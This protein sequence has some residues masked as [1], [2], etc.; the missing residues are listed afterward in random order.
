MRFKRPTIVILIFII[1]LFSSCNTKDVTE[2][3]IV[4][5]TVCKITG[6]SQIP[7]NQVW[8]TLRNLESK[9]NMNTA[10]SEIDQVNAKA[11]LEKVEVSKTTYDIIQTALYY[12]KLTDG[13]FNP[14]LGSVIQLWKEGTDFCVLPAPEAIEE[15]LKH[16]DI[17]KIELSELNGKYFIYLEDPDMRF[18]LGG[19]GKGVAADEVKTLL[20]DS[21]IDSALINLGG[22]IYGMGTKKDGS[23]WKIGIQ[24]PNAERGEYLKVV[25]VNDE[26]V[27]TSGSY[28]RNFIKDGI[29]YHHILDPSTGM[30]A[31]NGIISSTIINSDSTA[32]DC[33][34]TACYV[35]GIEKATKLIQSLDGFKAIFILESGKI[36]EVQ[37]KSNEEI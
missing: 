25:E 16:T 27:V 6:S 37:G 18:D 24:D 23:S 31:N 14:V 9:I 34:S 12:S 13:A 15:G 22:N 2:Q 33:L 11:G 4:F 21:G 35:M 1:I 8:E 28:E 3:N 36:L 32:C 30:S 29:K 26:S 7:F 17:N 20:L 10:N 5:G 19:I